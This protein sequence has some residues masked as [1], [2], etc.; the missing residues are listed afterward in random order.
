MSQPM[1]HQYDP[2]GID[3]HEA[4]AKL[5]GGRP[6]VWQGLLHYFPNSCRAIAHLSGTG[7]KKY[8]WG[9]WSAVEDAEAR[10]LDAAG[11]HFL[12]LAEEEYDMTYYDTEEGRK[13]YHHHLV[14]LAWNALAALEK[15]VTD[16]DLRTEYIED[17]PRKTDKP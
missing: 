14:S 4:G 5:D 2:Y 6:P 13:Y 1:Q 12:A 11:R 7:A 16:R 8:T 17:A 10:Y 9:G 3:Q 15:A